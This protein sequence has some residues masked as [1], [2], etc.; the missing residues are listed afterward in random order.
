M[1]IMTNIGIQRL[2]ELLIRAGELSP[3]E[4]VVGMKVRDGKMLVLELGE[5]AQPTQHGGGIKQ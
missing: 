5:R 3:K 1:S 2:T 4:K